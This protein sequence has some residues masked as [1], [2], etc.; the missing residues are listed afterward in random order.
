MAVC[1]YVFE[2]LVIACVCGVCWCACV[3]KSVMCVRVCLVCGG[4]LCVF[5]CP[6]SVCVCVVCGGV[7]V[8]VC[9]SVL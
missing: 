7:P 2:C 3:Y 6:V 1:L 5:E 9:V 8:C 4:C